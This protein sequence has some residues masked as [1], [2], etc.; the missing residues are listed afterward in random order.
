[1][2]IKT[3]STEIKIVSIMVMYLNDESEVI[4]S[5]EEQVREDFD[6]EKVVE[7]KNFAYRKMKVRKFT[8]DEH[9]SSESA[10]VLVKTE[11]GRYGFYY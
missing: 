11:T 10:I 1:M 5:F 3:T 6:F 4:A 2:G 9:N 8:A 7:L